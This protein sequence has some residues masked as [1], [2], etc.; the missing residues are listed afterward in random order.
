MTDQIF[1]N[2]NFLDELSI[3][4]LWIGIWGLSD[5]ILNAP[6]MSKYKHY[7][8]IIFILIAIYYKI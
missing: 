8:Y 3:I 6:L 1:L 2:I 4:F 5:M 7:F